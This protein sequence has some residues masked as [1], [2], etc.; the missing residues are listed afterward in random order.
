MRQTI[1][2]DQEL[3][4]SFVD[5]ALDSL[6]GFERAALAL[7]S[8]EFEDALQELF[9]S[10]HNLKGASM[11]IGLQ[12]FG[13][14]VHRVEDV[15]QHIINGRIDRSDKLIALLLSAHLCMSQWVKTL[16][17]SPACPPDVIPV[18]SELT[19]IINQ[20][21]KNRGAEGGGGGRSSTDTIENEEE[22]ELLFEFYRKRY[23]AEHPITQQSRS[24]KEDTAAVPTAP[25][26]VEDVVS[27]K[28]PRFK[29]RRSEKQDRAIETIRIS[30]QKLDEL[31]Q[32]VG[33]LSIH[34]SI[35]QESRKKETGISRASEHAFQLSQKITR[36]VHAKALELRMQ[37]LAGLM[38]KLE[39]TAVDLA[40]TQGKSIRVAIDAADV[41]LDKSVIEKISDALVHMIRNSVDHGVEEPSKRIAVGK[42]SEG[43]L[44]ITASQ[45][46]NEVRITISDDGQGMDD[47]V[48]FAAAVRKGIVRPDEKLAP[49]EIKNLIFVQGLSTAPKIT[50]ISGR[51]VGM[52]VVMATVKSLRGRIDIQSTVGVGTTFVVTLPTSLSI[53][54]ALVVNVG[55]S[56]YAVPMQE[57]TEIIDLSR[58]PIESV[59]RG[60]TMISLRGQ[61]VPVEPLAD[62]MSTSEAGWMVPRMLESNLSKGTTALLVRDGN[63]VVA[64][65]IDEIV[66]QQQIVV[67]P[68]SEQL[69]GLQG[70]R[71]CTILG[72]GSPGVILSLPDIARSYFS[73]LS[74]GDGGVV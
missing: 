8:A 60:G 68:L 44:A 66:S 4:A 70:L 13:D 67:R 41:Q 17:T 54:D 20:S 18:M 37:P 47:Q 53:I 27:D 29:S 62:Y 43:L 33:E 36:E 7:G 24:E 10:A 5:D 11:C 28:K 45:E 64:F 63:N 35:V 12:A 30:A 15:I 49:D 21:Q 61:V 50:E 40:N 16:A 2:I 38:Q 51:G 19:S 72:D 34:Q 9:R 55:E 73:S 39:R 65:A 6:T 22:L 25:P 52:D 48:I 14:F 31:I 57:L 74:Q 46:A 32:L 3:L 23:E 56:R 59:G 71:G 42:S 1:E 58:Y 26:R 69:E